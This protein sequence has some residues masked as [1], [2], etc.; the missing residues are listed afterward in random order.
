MSR[1]GSRLVILVSF[2]LSV[3]L[4]AGT[5]SDLF[6]QAKAQVKS[7]SW[8]E[9][10]TTLDR[11]E[12]ESV[13]PENETFHEQLVAPIAFY[14]GVCEANLDRTGKAEADF[15]I[16]LQAQPGSRIDKT[17]YSKKAVNAFEAAIRLAAHDAATKEA[18]SQSSVSLLRRFE[19]FR[20]PANLGEKPDG[21]WADGPVKWLLTPEETAGWT[22]LTG[23]AERTEFVEKF[24]ER[25]NPTPGSR[26]NPMRT[27]F[28]RRVAFADSYFRLDEQQRGSMSDPG[29]V[30]VLLG[31]PTRTGR[32]PILGTEE[33]NISDGSSVPG[34]WYMAERNSVHFDGFTTTD[35]SSGFREIWYYRRD[36]L[37]RAVSASEV[38]ATFVT[39]I[40]G[41]FVLQRQPEIL[42]ALG[43]ARS[44]SIPVL[45][46]SPDH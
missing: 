26:D 8:Q 32:K 39:K 17:T 18:A 22:A 20:S 19:E 16:F 31:P 12:A 27:A 41:R 1:L 45:S 3:P 9:A 4:S 34:Y 44:G 35:A 11:L 28:D 25:H 2:L 15:A 30:F 21:R 23:D 42:S 36:T 14:R 24:W 37:P 40:N 10:L 29:M 33:N 5:L 6:D 13:R 43:A 7:Q 46:T 38:E